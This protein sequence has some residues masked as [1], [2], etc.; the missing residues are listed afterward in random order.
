MAFGRKEI[1][2]TFQ[3]L[4]SQ[5]IS[6]LVPKAQSL[7]SRTPRFNPFLVRASVYWDYGR[8]PGICWHRCFN[9][10]LVRASV[11]CAERRR[12]PA[13]RRDPEFQSL[14]SQ[15]ISLLIVDPSRAVPSLQR[16][17]SLLSQGIS[18]LV[19]SQR[20]GR[21]WVTDNVSIPS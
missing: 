1:S 5:G 20:Q 6:L 13:G 9:P 14:L 4:L 18:L 16:F 12:K 7:Q 8:P 21:K 19:A 10:F 17:Q 3:S 15:G 2:E 11:Y